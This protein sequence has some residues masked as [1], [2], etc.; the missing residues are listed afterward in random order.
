MLRKNLWLKFILVCFFV[1]SSGC[2]TQEPEIIEPSKPSTIPSNAIWVGGVDGGVF[3]LVK[4]SEYSNE[5]EYI[6]E[7]YYVSGDLSYK[8]AM[9][10]IPD[11]ASL[12]I[13]LDS[14]ESY[15]GWDGD[16]LYLIGGRHLTVQE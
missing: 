2:E 9:K 14:K 1:L 15:Q 4:K 13:D 7:I 3:V 12:H 11:D 16:T 6:G 8:G 5:G 10:I